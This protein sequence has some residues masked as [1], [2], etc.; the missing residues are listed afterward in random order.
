MA[1]AAWFWNTALWKVA[2]G[3]LN[4]FV[5]ACTFTAAVRST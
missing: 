3:E 1:W 2:S 4:A 5:F